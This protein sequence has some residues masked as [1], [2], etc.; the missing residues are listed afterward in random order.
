VSKN[1]RRRKR[2]MDY[3][4][5]PLIGHKPDLMS[6]SRYN[7]LSAIAKYRNSVKCC[8]C[9]KNLE[10]RQMTIEHL[11]PTSKGGSN[12]IDNLYLAHKHCNNRQGNKDSFVKMKLVNKVKKR[13]KNFVR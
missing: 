3:P 5:Y 7:K 1:K 11:I 12:D 8:F 2:I 10:I 13:D 6:Q 4:D 9:G